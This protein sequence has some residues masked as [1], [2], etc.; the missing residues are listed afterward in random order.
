[1]TAEDA[2]LWSGI[3]GLV[4]FMALFAGVLAYALWPGNRDRFAQAARA[5]LDE[6]PDLDTPVKEKTS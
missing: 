4:F 5:P 1:M 6:D 3:L 2:S